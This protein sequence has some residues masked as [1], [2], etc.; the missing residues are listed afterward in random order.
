MAFENRKP[1]GDGPAAYQRAIRARLR[2]L[3]ARFAQSEIARRTRTPLTNVHRYMNT[4][5]IPA[6]FCAALVE[7]FEVNPAW[8]LVG[9]GGALLTEVDSG[10]GRVGGELLMMVEAMDAVARVR[11]G[12]LTGKEQEKALRKLS[13]ALGSYDRLRERINAQTR[14]V[15]KH[16]LDRYSS[17]CSHMELERAAGLRRACLQAAKFCDDEELLWELDNQQA[18]H[19]H[20]LGRVDAGLAFHLRL[21]ARKLRDGA[22]KDDASCSQAASLAL[23]LRDSGRFVEGRR[24]CRAAIE[25]AADEARQGLGFVEL[26]VIGG[27]FDVELGDLESGLAGIQRAFGLLAA[28]QRSFA[29]I[30][31]LRAE[32]LAGLCS[33][34]EARA[35]SYPSRG[36][37]RVLLRHAC[38]LEDADELRACVEHSIGTAEHQIPPNEYEACRSRLLL[39]ALTRPRP[40]LL[41]Q[42][43]TLGRESP[44]QVNS[45]HLKSAM[46]SIHHAQVARLCGKGAA[47]AERAQAQL[48]VVPRDRTVTIDLYAVQAR[49]LAA[50]QQRQALAVAQARLRDWIERGYNALRAVGI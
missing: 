41:R 42:F 36:R 50:T 38:L 49:N 8:L 3:R 23:A 48:D 7:A 22:L 21:F 33:I 43:E 9:A 34:A 27:S 39:T 19:E 30:L 15:L 40:A 13:D 17:L 26:C 1:G 46:L 29:S 18:M 24:I 10:A 37:S 5:K 11:L 16:L 12:A 14:P 6:E 45:P 28:G 35:R 20:L 47:E 2:E 31:L 4:G 25:L 32:L 44:P